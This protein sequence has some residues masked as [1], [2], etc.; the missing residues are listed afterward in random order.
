M[1]LFDEALI[2]IVIPVYNVRQYID[3]CIQSVLAQN[4]KNL[5]ILLI[6]DGSTDGSGLA[7]DI[8]AESDSRIRVIHKE[9]GGL[10]DAR[11]VGIQ[12]ARGDYIA[13]ID[14]DDY[15]HKAF[16]DT[17]IKYQRQ[18]QA[19]IVICRYVK[20][21]SDAFPAKRTDNI[22]CCVFNS[23]E[24]LTQWHSRFK[25]IETVAWNK[26]YAKQLFID[27]NIM[28]PYGCNNEDV[29]TTHLLVNASKRVCVIDAKLYYYFQRSESITNGVIS[30][31][32]IH[33]NIKS[34]NKRLEFFYNS[35]YWGAYERLRI[36][37][38]KFYMLT[39]CRVNDAVMQKELLDQYQKD[40]KDVLKF[41][42][43]KMYEK[44]III[45]FNYFYKIIYKLYQ[46]VRQGK[47]QKHAY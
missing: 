14:A 12:T 37:R 46:L 43:T 32:S 35:G 21:S 44:I 24:M 31:K 40:Y 7:C 36:K 4:Y 6:D 2:S 23:K 30:E 11:N 1:C 20:G 16:I 17:M 34:Q 3:R 13:F 8:Y 10:S 27:S 26:L 39:Y 25:H 9:N 38:L 19:D 33:D 29:Q 15:V 41:Q 18:N 28:F 5:E 42:Q 45:Q 47:I 22:K